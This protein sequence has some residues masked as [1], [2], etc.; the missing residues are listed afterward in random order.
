MSMW[1]KPLGQ[2]LLLPESTGID[3]ELILV[4]NPSTI[5]KTTYNLLLAVCHTD[6]EY[7]LQMHPKL[8][9]INII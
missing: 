4:C 6:G 9:Y 3:P 5:R 2:N 8:R 7:S 1:L